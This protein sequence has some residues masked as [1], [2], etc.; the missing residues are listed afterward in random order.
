VNSFTNSCPKTDPIH[1]FYR[2][3]KWKRCDPVGVPVLHDNNHTLHADLDK[4]NCLNIYFSSV[5][6][7]RELTFTCA[8]CYCPSVCRLSVCNV[9]ASCSGGWNFRPSV[10]INRKFYEDRPRGTLPSMELNPSRVAKYSDFEH[11]E[12]SVS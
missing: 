4:A 8:I 10:D 9:R 1:K 2:F 5:F 11:I 7:E 3:I 12:G 6:S